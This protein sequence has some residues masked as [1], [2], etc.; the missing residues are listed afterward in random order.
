M[1]IFD[2]LVYSVFTQLRLLLTSSFP[3]ASAAEMSFP[4]FL[5]SSTLMLVFDDEEV[6][7][8]L[9]DCTESVEWPEREE[10]AKWIFSS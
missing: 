6:D 4:T 2:Y 8:I 3:S 10:A 9:K 1:C 7:A 5:T